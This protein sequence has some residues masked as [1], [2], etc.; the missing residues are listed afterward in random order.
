MM[1]LYYFSALNTTAACS[2]RSPVSENFSSRNC[3]INRSR[4]Y[5]GVPRASIRGQTSPI[6]PPRASR[7][8]R[9]G[10]PPAIYQTVSLGLGEYDEE[11]EVMEIQD[12]PSIDDVVREL[13]VAKELVNTFAVRAKHYWMGWGPVAMPM[14][15]TIDAWAQ[16]QLQYLKWLRAGVLEL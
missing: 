4:S 14:I 2:A 15:L 6:L 7:T 9:S 12:S 16:G 11:K 5:F 13:D 8:P 1:R 3:L 10:S